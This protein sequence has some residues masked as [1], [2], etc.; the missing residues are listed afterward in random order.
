MICSLDELGLASERAAGI[1]PL[2]EIFS[3]DYLES[4]LG[5][6]FYEL[7][8]SIPG[9]G[10]KPAE[11]KIADTVFEIDNKFITNRPDLFSVRGNAREFS[12]LYDLPLNPGI[13]EAT[14]SEKND[15]PV[16]IKSDKVLSYH[17]SLFSGIGVGK[18]PFGMEILLQKSEQP[19]KFDMVDLT[20]Y[21]MTEY[22]QPMH[23]FDADKVEGK[24]IVRDAKEGEKILALDGKEYTLTS[25]DL[26]I[27]DEEKALA[28]A[29]V[30]GGENSAISE[31]T[32]NVVFEAATFD[33]VSVRM[34][35]ARIG[36]RTDASTRFEKSQ[37]P[38]LAALAMKRTEEILGFMGKKN[39]PDAIFSYVNTSKLKNI[40]IEVTHDFIAKKLGR[41]IPEADINRILTALGF[42]YAALDANTFSVKVPSWRATKDVSIK[43][44]I[45]EEVG[46]IYGYDRIA[47]APIPGFFSIASKNNMIAWKSALADAFVGE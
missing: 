5:T 37:D 28:V 46:R 1:L 23:A 22:G 44:D 32:K 4:K 8:V 35:A 11:V 47:D 10:G 15:Y 43:E 30:I 19:V 34:T 24:I 39:T 12:A 42:E 40:S 20:N 45:A 29:G 2:E 38:M 27:A 9:I 3:E 13:T 16:E 41:A 17:L 7:A 6:P 26:V 31:T 25:K 36:C 21:V 18:T 33:P 14:I